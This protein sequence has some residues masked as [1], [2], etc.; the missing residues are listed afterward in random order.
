M[1]IDAVPGQGTSNRPR[2]ARRRPRAAIPHVVT[3]AVLAV[4]LYPVAWMVATA[5][6]SSEE[7]LTNP[8]LLP[9]QFTLDNFVQ[10]WDGAGVESFTVFFTNS[11]IIAVGAV[12][13]NVVSCSLAA[14]AF[15]RLRFRA[16]TAL[17]AICIAM[18]LMPKE[19]LLIPQYAIFHRLGWVDSPLPL[20][21]P[22][23]LA[24]DAFFVFLNVQF[25]RGLPEELDEAAALDGCGPL[26]RLWF[27][28]MP[29]MRPAI[30]T[31]SI[32]TFIWAWNDYMPQ[33]I[34]LNSPE[35]YTLPVGLRM[36]L[37]ATSGS[38]L[39]PMTAMSLAALL[40]LFGLFLFFQRR[41]VQGIATT[42]LK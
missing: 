19:V 10:G 4:M 42:G 26:R 21:V 13:G 24:A 23:F 35:N 15:A 29:L 6:K 33:L 3:V 7:I 25:L 18:L 12:I 32:F 22:H 14:Y 39:G 37:D 2:Q 34:Y 36:F 9:R 20:L 40:P 11:T 30:A 41:L 17:F 1:G 16:R 5:F 8:S 28:T 38:E 27:I 31:T